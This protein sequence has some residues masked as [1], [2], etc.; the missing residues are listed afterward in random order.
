M[1]TIK[2]MRQWVDRLFLRARERGLRRVVDPTKF[3]EYDAKGKLCRVC[4][5]GLVSHCSRKSPLRSTISNLV[6]CEL[7]HREDTVS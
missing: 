3:T 1:A 5:L 4:V 7:D 6:M 2:Q